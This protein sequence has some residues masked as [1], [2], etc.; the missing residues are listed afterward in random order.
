MFN[1]LFFNRALGCCWIK[2]RNFLSSW[3]LLTSID[4]GTRSDTKIPNRAPDIATLPFLRYICA[5]VVKLLYLVKPVCLK[6]YPFLNMTKKK[7]KPVD[8]I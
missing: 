3:I 7:V 6:N 4:L 5:D 2:T 8:Y 1:G